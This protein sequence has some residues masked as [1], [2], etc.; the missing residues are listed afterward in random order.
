MSPFVGTGKYWE[1]LIKIEYL[2]LV[3]FIIQ[4]L[5]YKFIIAFVSCRLS[6]IPFEIFLK[7][8]TNVTAKRPNICTNFC[9]SV[10]F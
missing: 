3:L 2:S 5:R 1:R 10:D 8:F 4:L 6:D 9:I 7:F